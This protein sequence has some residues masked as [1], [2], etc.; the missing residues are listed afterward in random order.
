MT[1]ALILIGLA[2]GG[3]MFGPQFLSGTSNS[4]HALE[5][6]RLS[7]PDVE[8]EDWQRGLGQLFSGVAKG[9][10]ARQAMSEQYPNMPPAV[11]C[12][13]GYWTNGLNW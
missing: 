3:F 7:D 5:Q 8:L 12:A 1:K 6:A 9:G 4:C 13:V 10:I 11:M 2:T